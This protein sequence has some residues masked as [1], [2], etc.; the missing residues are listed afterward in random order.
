M[1]YKFF[2]KK[3]QMGQGLT[4]GLAEELHNLIKRKFQRPFVQV[5]SIDEGF[6]NG[7]KNNA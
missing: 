5:S 4:D 2:E 1:M 6:Q 7:V 3:I